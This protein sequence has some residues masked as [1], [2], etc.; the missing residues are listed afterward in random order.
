M[1]SELTMMPGVFESKIKYTM[2]QEVTSRK[3]GNAKV[4]DTKA[5]TQRKED[6][7]EVRDTKIMI[8]E[9]KSLEKEENQK[10]CE[11]ESHM[12]MAGQRNQEEIR[13][14]TWLIDSGCTN[15]MTPNERIFVKIDTSIKVPIRVGNGAVMI[16]KGKRDIEVMTKKGKRII[17]DVLLVPRLGKNL[18]S[19]P[20]MISNGYQVNFKNK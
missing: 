17:K 20:Q 16:S 14:R 10:K 8:N 19:V 4:R 15:H 7:I 6:M 12:C 3:K 2:N 5:E 9:K 18:L 13:E 1:V 11:G